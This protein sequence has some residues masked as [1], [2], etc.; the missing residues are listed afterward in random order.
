[1]A[2]FGILVAFHAIEA[3]EQEGQ[4]FIDAKDDNLCFFND[5]HWEQIQTELQLLCTTLLNSLSCTGR[6]SES[7][8]SIKDPLL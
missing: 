8:A 1:M 5:L 6:R 4:T 7:L 3:K 2:E